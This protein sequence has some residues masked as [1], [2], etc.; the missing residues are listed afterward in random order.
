MIARYLFIAVLVGM[1]IITG[2]QDTD[3]PVYGPDNPDPNPPGTAAAVLTAITPNTGYLLE[4]VTITGSGFNPNPA[5]NFVQFGTGI[6]TV[7]TAS[8][9]ELN[10]R[11]AGPWGCYGKL[12]GS[13]NR[14]C[15]I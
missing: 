6:G 14:C 13:A 1:F 7:L 8:A 11:I 10:S 15:G 12:S 5:D 3:N 2:C 9:T 4:V